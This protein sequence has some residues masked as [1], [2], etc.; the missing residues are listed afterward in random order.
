MNWLEMAANIA[1]VMTAIVAVGA[2]IHY[3]R[4]QTRKREKLEQY[5]KAER[6]ANPNKHTHTILHVMAEVA[7]TNDE[8]L[9]ASFQSSH[10]EHVIHSDRDT[11]L[12]DDILLRYKD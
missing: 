4:E 5:L 12:A 1:E 7:L 10:I 11:G 9:R 3:R 2:Y 6:A 8:V